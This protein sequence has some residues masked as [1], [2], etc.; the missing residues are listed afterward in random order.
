MKQI[1]LDATLGKGNSVDA[2]TIDFIDSPLGPLMAGAD[3]SGFSLLEFS[4][5]HRIE[6]QLDA[7][8][9]MF[10]RPLV[11]GK[12]RLFEP[13]RRQLAEY[14]D[15][16]RRCFDL[17]L[18]IAGTPFQERVWNALLAIPYGEVRSY[19]EV[20]KAIGAP[21]AVRAV[22]RANGSNRISIISPCHRVIGADGS[23]VG[24]GGGPRRKEWLLALE[25]GE[26]A[27]F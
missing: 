26:R 13:L 22:G 4:D 9:A 23:I 8:R 14:F 19:G 12:H 21:Q 10:G 18:R 16:R 15:G 6:S 17:P 24:Y 1:A 3:D 20:A 25:R 5:R 7:W 2:L 11:P 27:L